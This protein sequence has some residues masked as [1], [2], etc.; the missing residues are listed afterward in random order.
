[1]KKGGLTVQTLLRRPVLYCFKILDRLFLFLLEDAG[2]D[3]LILRIGLHHRD[4]I[5]SAR[6]P[7]GEVY[8]F[9]DGPLAEG[10]PVSRYEQSFEF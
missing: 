4:H 3:G 8:S 2:A 9:P 6:T 1:V 5:E 10:G 7:P